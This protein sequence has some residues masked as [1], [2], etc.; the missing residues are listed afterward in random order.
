MHGLQISAALEFPAD[1]LSIL[2]L[3]WLGRRLRIFEERN[4]AI[5]SQVVSRSLHVSCRDHHLA[6][7]LAHRPAHATSNLCH[8]W[9]ILCHL[10][11]EHWLSVL[12]WGD[13]SKHQSERPCLPRCS[14]PPWEGREWQWSTWCPWSAK[15]HRPSLST[16]WAY[17]DTSH[18]WPWLSQSKLS[19]KAPWIIISLI[20]IIASIPGLDVWLAT[21]SNPGTPLFV[22]LYSSTSLLSNI[23]LCSKVSSCLRQLEWTF[24]TIWRAWRLLESKNRNELRHYHVYPL[25]IV[26]RNDRFFW[27]PLLGSA[28]REVKPKTSDKK[29]IGAEDNPAFSSIWFV[30][31]LYLKSYTNTESSIFLVLVISYKFLSMI[32]SNVLGGSS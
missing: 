3:E 32:D 9:K 17:S 18:L 23:F 30:F 15:W 5:L 8:G 29:E 4:Q 12:S 1:L 22:Q 20:A 25:L 10:R 31:Y 2:G 16:R 21:K 13:L 11:H 14:Q 26:F 19:E 6:L 27:M 28:T 7:R 24:L